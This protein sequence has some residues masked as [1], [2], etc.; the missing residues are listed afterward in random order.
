MKNR[1][2]LI[3]VTGPTCSGKT[4]LGITLGKFFKSEIISYDSR[5]FYKNMSIGTSVPSEKELKKCKHHFIQHKKITDNYNIGEYRKDALKLLKILFKKNNF[6]ILVGGSGLYAD[7]LIYGLDQ[8]PEVKKKTKEEVKEIYINEGILKI[9]EILK[10][11]DPEYYK[12]VD[13]NNPQRVIRAVEICMSSNSNYSFF[14]GKRKSPD[15]FKTISIN[16]AMERARLYEKINT[17]V[18]KMI[19]EGL[20]GEVKSLFKYSKLNS[21]QTVGYKEWFGYWNKE[22]SYSKTIEL[23]KRNTRRYAKRQITWNKKYD[24][25]LIYNDSIKKDQLISLILKKL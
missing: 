22:Y 14:L 24:E 9:K 1:N 16:I 13:L 8:F 6:V 11:K 25:A 3:H 20:E 18:D 5:Q 23:I 2:Y 12:K 15:F 19:N 17:R 10:N 7:S 4:A 21:L